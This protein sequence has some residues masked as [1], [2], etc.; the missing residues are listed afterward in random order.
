MNV[1]EKRSISLAEARDI[2]E[3]KEKEYAEKE[4]DMSYEQR[5]A[6]D[7]ARKSSKLSAKDTK[8]L[9][10][11]LNCMELKLKSDQVIKICDL[12]PETVD[13]VRAIFAKERFKYS[14]DEI[15]QILDL[16]AQHR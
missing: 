4:I 1:I 14:E 12:L 10:E 9:I 15:K 6:L 2:L 11:K 16:I 13:D 8:E 3:S 5:R 7:H